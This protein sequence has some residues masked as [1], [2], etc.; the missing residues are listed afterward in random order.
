MGNL[1]TSASFTQ[2]LPVLTCCRTGVRYQ[3]KEIDI[4]AIY[5]AYS[6]FTALIYMY[7]YI[8]ECVFVSL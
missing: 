5:R 3:D 1:H 6:D 4:S 7:M 2:C 8:H